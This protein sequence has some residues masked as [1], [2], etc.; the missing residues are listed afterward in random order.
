MRKCGILLSISSLPSKYGTG[1]L[2][3]SAYDFVD[4]LKKDGQ[5][6]CGIFSGNVPST[7]SIKAFVRRILC[8]LKEASDGNAHEGRLAKAEFGNCDSEQNKDLH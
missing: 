5:S 7:V 8:K 2:G 1:T 6:Y 3:K 4:F